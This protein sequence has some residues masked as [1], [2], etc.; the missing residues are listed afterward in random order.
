MPWMTLPPGLESP[1]AARLFVQTWLSAWGLED[2]LAH[3]GA[4]G[5]AS[6]LATNAAL[7]TGLEFDVGIEP[8][9]GRGSHRSPRPG[10]ECSSPA[11]APHGAGPE[12]THGRGLSIVA[13][14]CADWGSTPLTDGKEVWCELT[15]G[16]CNYLTTSR[17]F[18]VRT[19]TDR[20]DRLARLEGA[21]PMATRVASRMSNLRLLL[22]E[23]D[24]GDALPSS[25][26]S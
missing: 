1:R 14:V 12:E 11:V 20:N 10:A 18:V 21:A 6:E 26:S 2:L 7:H 3:R 5:S 25:R 9:R 16:L 13:A 22:V 19:T 23:D 8:D 4:D 24:D 15:S 17:A